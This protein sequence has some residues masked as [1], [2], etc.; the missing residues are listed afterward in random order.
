LPEVEQKFQ[1]RQT[2]YK[3]RVQ[4]ILDSRYIKTEGFAPNYLEIQNQEISRI[5]IIGV[6][7]QKSGLDNYKTLVIE[8]NTGKISAR[9]FE[10]STLL[11]NVE[12]S[13][14]VLVIGRPREFSS[15]KYVL[16][17]TI[18]KINPRWAEVRK[19]ELKKNMI[20][21]KDSSNNNGAFSNNENSTEETIVGLSP[22]NEII[23]L[24]KELDKGNGVSIE[25][26]PS[27]NIRDI[28]KTID[29]LLKE[30]DIFEIKPG[31]L[32]VLE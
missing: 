13:D 16:I 29:M 12:V 6:V 28:D 30:G 24:I 19:L 4:D 23:K 8:D 3:V 26:L 32:K 21:Y 22:A 14:I 15:E 2:A 17:E 5:N 1:R 31:K 11:D 10:N 20:D 27:K 9:I 18:R 25:E 7:I